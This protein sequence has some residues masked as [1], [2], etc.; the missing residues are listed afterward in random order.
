M[1]ET[2]KPDLSIITIST[3]EGHELN[4]CLASV[5]Q[6]VDNLKIEYFLV[7]NASTDNTGDIAD[8]YPDVRYIEN[9][10]VKGFAS[11]NNLAMKQSTGRYILLLNP[12]T[13]MEPQTLPAMVEYLDKHEEIGA[14]SCKLTNPDNT[15]Q[16]N[17]R[18]FPT[19]MAV[20]MRWLGFDRF[21]PNSKILKDYLLKDWDH[22]TERDVDWLI[23]AFLMVRRVVIDQVGYL[24]ESYDPLYYEDIDWCFRIKK[25]GWRIRYIPHV[26]CT[27][28]YD[29]ESAR[30]LFNKMTYIHLK[31]CIRFFSRHWRDLR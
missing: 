21:F 1:T 16:Y 12:D 30:S 23:G 4:S 15:I 18:M 14:A 10:Q 17:A 11:N 8:Q 28:L 29:R 6:G 31:N 7:N 26:K 2:K 5:F 27:H 3:N 24:D 9:F 25:A 19:P 13:M 20:I 22:N